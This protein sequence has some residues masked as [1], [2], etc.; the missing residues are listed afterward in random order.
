M[1]EL[2]EGFWVDPWDVKAIRA[3]NDHSCSMWP[4]GQNAENGFVLPYEAS[5]VV[6]AVIDA[7]NESE[8]DDEDDEGVEDTE[9]E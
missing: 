8:D 5:E 7:R 1:I 9:D 3:I 6:D 2:I 4:T